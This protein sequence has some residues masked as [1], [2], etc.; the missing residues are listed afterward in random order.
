MSTDA[1]IF[2]AIVI[3]FLWHISS[4]LKEI[5]KA[6][7]ENTESVSSWGDE[8]VAAIRPPITDV[9]ELI[10]EE[11]RKRSRRKESRTT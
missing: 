10:D 8:I 7:I 11:E 9:D 6:L 1:I 3:L 5:L 4:Q 2:D